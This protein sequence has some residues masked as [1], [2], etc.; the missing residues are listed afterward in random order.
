ML[1]LGNSPASE[2]YMLTFRN[3]LFHLHRPVGT[4]L[5]M[6]MEQS[7][8]KCRNIKFR[9]QKKGYNIQN[10]VKVWNQECGC[11]PPCHLQCFGH[12]PRVHMLSFIKCPSKWN[13]PETMF[14]KKWI[15]NEHQ[16]FPTA[17]PSSPNIRWWYLLRWCL[18][19]AINQ[20]RTP[21]RWK[22]RAFFLGGGG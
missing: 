14:M 8:Q 15:W 7:V 9:R 12:M 19:T 11:W 16:I 21:S 10:T 22:D 3:T 17:A 2:F 6:K 20:T 1:F 18:V 4:Y 13:S 5:P